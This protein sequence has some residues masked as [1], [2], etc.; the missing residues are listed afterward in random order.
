MIF[1]PDL[2]PD[3]TTTTAAVSTTSSTA[4][5]A[6]TTTTAAPGPGI[7][8]NVAVSVLG[9]VTGGAPSS[10]GPVGDYEVWLGLGSGNV[11]AFATVDTQLDVSD[12][13]DVGSGQECSVT[14]WARNMA[15]RDWVDIRI[16]PAPTTTTTVAPA[17]PGVPT[18]VTISGSVLSWDAPTSGGTVATYSIKVVFNRS[19]GPLAAQAVVSTLTYDASTWVNLFGSD[20][21]VQIRAKNSAGNSPWTEAVSSNP[22]P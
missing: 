21:T 9:L 1:S 15:G 17:A 10:G 12:H 3:T 4:T 18:N 13:V 7:P 8:A 22:T 11:P 2:G 6:A 5:T 14:V 16:N 20:F 19:S